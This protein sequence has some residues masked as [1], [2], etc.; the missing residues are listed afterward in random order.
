M[1]EIK[2]LGSGYVHIRG[3]G[4]CN[5]S[6]PPHWPCSD[7]ILRQ[8]A[9]PEASEEFLH[10]ANREALYIQ[11]LASEFGDGIVFCECGHADNEH[12]FAIRPGQPAPCNKCLCENFEADPIEDDYEED[13]SA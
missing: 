8:N 12:S 3:E 9:H 5:W 2:K 10:A 7:E 4:T 13:E 6:Q 1:I 11:Q